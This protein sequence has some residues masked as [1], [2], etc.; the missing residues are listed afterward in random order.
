M[1]RINVLKILFFIST[2]NDQKDLSALVITLLKRF[3][4]AKVL[5]VDD[6]S[7]PVITLDLISLKEA[8][9]AC[10]VRLVNNEGL[11]LTTNIAL[12]YMLQENFDCL[13]RLDADGQHPLSEIEGL[14]E[15]ISSNLADVVWGERVN[16]NLKNTPKAVMGS[17]TKTFTAWLGRLIF[18]SQVMDWFTGF[19]AINQLAAKAAS[20]AYLERY[21]E[22]Q[23]LCI[24][25]E[26]KLRVDTHP[27][28]QL[29]R[30]QG[31]SSIDWLAGLMIF[32]RST[33]MML[34]YAIGMQPK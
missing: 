22:V 18:K 2:L 10:L 8:Q 7:M 12:D 21:C 15:K 17:V 20:G 5:I 3:Q 4:Q 31:Q 19:F 34:L 13:V 29:E 27:I 26:S 24:F 25:H 11:G 32:L 1:Q 6:G 9:R 14:T 30:N 23:L 33:L 16:H 28:E